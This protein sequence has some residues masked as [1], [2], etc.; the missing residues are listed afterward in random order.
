MG[1]EPIDVGLELGEPAAELLLG[2]LAGFGVGFDLLGDALN[3]VLEFLDAFHDLEPFFLDFAF[4]DFLGVDLGE[5]GLIFLV[6]VGV[7]LLGAE[8][9]DAGVAGFHVQVE[10]PA[11]DCC[12]RSCCW[13]SLSFSLSSA[14]RRSWRRTLREALSRRPCAARRA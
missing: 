5:E 7:L 9:F 14:M 13:V 4:V 6:I 1:F 11:L 3:F 2:L 10:S 8:F 12:S